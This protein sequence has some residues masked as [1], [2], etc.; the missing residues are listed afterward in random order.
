MNIQIEPAVKNSQELRV[1]ITPQS[2]IRRLSTIY[3]YTDEGNLYVPSPRIS[4]VEDALSFAR[5]LN[6]IAHVWRTYQS[7]G[8]GGKGYLE[9]LSHSS[10]A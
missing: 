8:K 4:S 5:A 9:T 3:F 1:S 2:S 7:L 10:N 6:E